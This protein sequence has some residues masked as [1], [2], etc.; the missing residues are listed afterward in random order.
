MTNLS[1]HR[2]S[3]DQLN[4]ELT[5]LD[6]RIR[7]IKK[8]IESQ[9]TQSD[10]KEQMAEFVKVSEHEVAILQNYMKEL[11]T[12]RLKLA[13]FFVEDVNTFKMEEC[14]KVFQNF[15]ER[16]KQ[17]LVENE[18]RRYQEEQAAMRR[19]QR[20]DQLAAKKKS[21]INPFCCPRNVP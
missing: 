4:N 11:T 15:R 17:A 2:T 19:K 7:K 16:F 8:Q 9:Q 1:S 21:M 3:V 14:Y 20:E 13:E 10:I 5:A 12:L 18:R 6:T